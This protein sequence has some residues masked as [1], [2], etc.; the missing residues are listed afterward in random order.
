MVALLVSNISISVFASDLNDGVNDGFDRYMGGTNIQGFNSWDITD[1]KSLFATNIVSFFSSI[2][3]YFRNGSGGNLMDI[4]TTHLIESDRIENADNLDEYIASHLTANTN[5]TELYMS[6]DLTNALHETAVQYIEEEAGWFTLKTVPFAEISALNFDTQA[7]YD[8]LIS[9][10][11]SLPVDSVIKIYSLCSDLD[12]YGADGS[13]NACRYYELTNS[14]YLVNYTS[15][16]PYS[17]LNFIAYNSNWERI[18]EYYSIYNMTSHNVT[19]DNAVTVDNGYLRHWLPGTNKYANECLFTKT[20]REIRI[21]NS[22]DDLK[23]Y[24]VG[25]RPYY[26]T[27]KFVNYDSTVDNSTTITQTEIDNSVTYGD[28]YNYITNNYENPDGLSEDEL[29]AIL[30][31]YLSQINNSDGTGSDS[32]SG[33][34]GGSGGGLSGFLDGLGS[35]GNAILAI[36]S[37][38]MEILGSAIELV[39]GSITD[40]ITIIPNSIGELLGALFPVFPEEWIKAITLS[41]VLGVIVGIVR[42][43]K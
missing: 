15:I 25:E 28:V 5:E 7:E 9:Y 19:T 22:L 10:F 31:E 40:L 2:G 6:S 35:I 26:V 4:F 24:S 18:S 39:T 37:K 23:M 36:L 41:L 16:S 13:G 20:G 43:F 3:M 38:L 30:E 11:N 14:D 8:S 21:Y 33:D 17:W 27:E 29:R 12:E 32:S 42:M 1:K 34:S